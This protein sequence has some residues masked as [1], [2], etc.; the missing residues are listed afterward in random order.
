[1]DNNSDEHFIIIWS[2]IEKSKQEMKAK[3]QGSD[4]KIMKVTEDLKEMIESAI[5]SMM[6]QIKMSKSSS[7]Q[8][9]FPKPL[10]TTTVVPD[11]RRDPPLEVG[12]STK[13]GGVWYLKHEIRSPKFYELLIKKELKEDTAMDLKNFYNHI[14]MCLNV[15]AR[16]Q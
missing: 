14:N 6:D 9:D 2:T 8:K 10:E 13:I 4:Y 1:M 5:T 3:N 15:V 11:N 12:H 7:S 16:L